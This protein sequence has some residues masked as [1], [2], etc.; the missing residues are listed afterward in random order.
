MAVS[1]KSMGAASPDIEVE[2]DW[3]LLATAA[4]PK[5][6]T[7]LTPGAE[8]PWT[9]PETLVGS[10]L[11][12]RYKLLRLIGQG[13]MG[14]VYLAEHVVIG[15]QIAVKVL[16]PDYSRNPGDVQRFLQEA[17]AASLIRHDHVVDIADF[18]RS[19]QGH[20]YIVMEYLEGEDLARTLQTV[21]V[22]KWFRVSNIILQISSALAAAHAKGIIHRDMKPENCFRVKR[23]NETDY[24]KV[25]DFGIA[26][27]VDDRFTKG[28]HSLTIEGG[29]I[30]TPEY[31][32]PELCRGL[33]ADS[34]V[35]IY[36]LGVIMYRMLTGVLPFRTDTDN[37]MAVLSQHLTDPPVPPREQN[38]S[39]EIP[40]KIEQIVLKA[41]EKDPARRYQK[42]EELIAALR[43]AQ[44]TLTGASSTGIMLGLPTMPRPRTIRKP[45]RMPIGLLLAL[46][47]VL[48]LGVA[49]I[50]WTLLGGNFDDDPTVATT[51]RQTPP[52]PT[53]EP[54]PQPPTP[55]PPP[56]AEPTIVGADTDS[57]SDTGSDP[58]NA[59][60]ADTGAAAPAHALPEALSAAEFRRSIAPLQRSLKASCPG[61]R[62]FEVG[63]KV[64]VDA[65]G[66]VS[67]V[68]PEGRQA[69]SSFSNCV[70]KLVR[71]TR[72][73]RA[74]KDSVHSATFK[75]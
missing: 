31:I 64:Y 51:R 47:G 63:A 54:T 10:L 50:A 25:L 44:M 40:P 24:I 1:S 53:P 35:D 28:Q 32:A 66:K 55:P 29:I 16:S 6:Q 59:S 19:P 60:D 74:R 52:E 42:V 2:D 14:A 21:G 57:D 13:G 43:E 56:I 48:I 30:G 23:D 45:P 62:G 71:Q 7:Q 49:A 69:G 36:A 4:A 33:K 22:M 18:G 15:K 11:G 26:K 68:V 72:F 73:K 39:A 12:E 17:R 38:P 34:R 3:E 67:R 5:Q 65:S 41:L 20:A 61:L 75:L 70:V 37:Y 58:G 8:Q 9:D 27:I 46:V